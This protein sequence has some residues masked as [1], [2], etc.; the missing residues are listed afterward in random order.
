MHDDT[1]Q[2]LADFAA[3]VEKNHEAF[4]GES[5]SRPP[6]GSP[7]LARSS[8]GR[9]VGLL[10]LAFVCVGQGVMAG[11]MFTMGIVGLETVSAAMYFP[12]LTFLCAWALSQEP[13]IRDDLRG[14]SPR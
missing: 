13:N 2:K 3:K 9:M 12:A 10:T 4:Y 14:A 6:E 11:L 1:D 5:V 7:A 8:S